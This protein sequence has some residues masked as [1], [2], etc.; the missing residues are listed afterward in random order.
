MLQSPIA[1]WS[2][3]ISAW[4][5]RPAGFVKSSSHAPSAPCGGRVAGDVEHDGNGAKR[6]GEPARAGRLLA[7]QAKPG[8]D[9]LVLQPGGEA[10]DAQLHEHERRALDRSPAVGGAR[11]PARESLPA[12]DPGGEPADDVQPALVDVV[13]DDLGD[14][15]PLGAQAEALDQLG[16][17]GAAAADNRDLGVFNHARRL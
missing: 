5:T 16:G 6:L 11:E 17:V 7:D 1:R 15:Q 10:A 13:Q 3:S 2:W 8:R 12:Q 9:G 14:A 4:A